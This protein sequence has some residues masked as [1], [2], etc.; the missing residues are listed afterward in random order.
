M[1]EMKTLTMPNGNTYEIVDA[2]AR[3]DIV[4]AREAVANVNNDNKRASAPPITKTASGYPI[5]VNDS[6]ERP[7]NNLRVFGKTTQVTMDDVVTPTPDNPLELVSAENPTTTILGGNLIPANYA[8]GKSKTMNGI[9]FE[10]QPDGSILVNGTATA[11]AYFSF[12]TTGNKIVMPNGWLSTS[13]G[14]GCGTNIPHVQN[15]IYVDGIYINAVQT[16]IESETRRQFF[17]KVE[18]GASRVKVDAGVTVVS[19]LVY[20]MLCAFEEPIPYEA[21]KQ[22]QTLPL[23]RTLRGV[24]VTSHG[25]YTDENGQQWICDEIDFER[26]VYIQRVG[27]TRFAGLE[28]TQNSSGKYFC[29]EDRGV[30]NNAH[31]PLCTHVT[32]GLPSEDNEANVIFINANNDIRLNLELEEDTVE[33]VTAE[34]NDAVLYGALIIPV[35][36]ALTEEELAAFESL[37]SHSTATT[38][39]ND[40]G[41]GMEMKYSADL[42]TYIENTF[43]VPSAEQIENAVINYL[44]KNPISAGSTATIGTVNLLASKWV[45]SGNLYSQVVSITGVTKNSQVDLT[46]SVEQLVAFYEK[47]LTFVTENDDGVV[48]VYAIGQKP[49][50]DYSIQV[51]ITEVKR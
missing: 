33:A 42:Q 7:L 38:V 23:T 27:V 28:W 15:D 44:Q 48:T 20:P 30:Y 22:S 34:M 17:G 46:P 50:N 3:E 41:A 31:A 8:D 26:G 29:T 40:S 39:F 9:T 18:L 37:W 12:N 49:A 4:K 1:K 25:N 47:D 24:P 11:T 21:P 10:V 6:A 13:S 19:Q 45:G 43:G 35:E 32:G 36:T 5:A 51:T 14:I 16:A 2:K